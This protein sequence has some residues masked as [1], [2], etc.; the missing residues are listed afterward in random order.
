[1]VLI[2]GNASADR[3]PAT[4]LRWTLVFGIGIEP[5][6][7]TQFAMGSSPSHVGFDDGTSPPR[8]PG[9]L[10]TNLNLADVMAAF[11]PGTDFSAPPSGPVVQGQANVPSNQ[12]AFTVRLSVRDDDNPSSLTTPPAPHSNP[13][14]DRKVFFVHHDP[15]KHKGWPIAIDAN[16]DGLIDGGGEPPPHMV[17]LDGD[18]VMELVQ[19]TAAGRIYAFRADGSQLP[20]FPVT[21][22]MARNVATHLAAP[23][24]ASG[25]I[26]PPSPTT[27]SRPAFGDLDHDGYPEIVVA[28]MD[29]HV[30]AWDRTGT[31]LPGWPVKIQDSNPGAGQT[32][33]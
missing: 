2:V 30:Y 17:D 21:T 31:L 4:A 8:R 20:G 10:L 15:T 7:F 14:E 18:N 26:A 25:R 24:F 19:A 33:V 5:A 13:G 29:Q 23:A 32:P 9:A 6:S 16:G 12:F 1:M 27:T 11:P 28:A 3:G 22:N